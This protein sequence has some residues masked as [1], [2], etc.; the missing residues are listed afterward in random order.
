MAGKGG[1]LFFHIRG[2]TQK[3]GGGAALQ[4]CVQVQGKFKGI[5]LVIF[6]RGGERD[7][8]RPRGAFSVNWSFC[9]GVFSLCAT[10]RLK[11]G[12]LESGVDVFLNQKKKFCG[13]FFLVFSNG[14]KQHWREF[15]KYAFTAWLSAWTYH[16]DVGPH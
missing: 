16:S 3:D 8:A 7:A 11:V 1:G 10:A 6:T 14:E 2:Q 12:H 15:W 9:K 13:L 5:V 4:G